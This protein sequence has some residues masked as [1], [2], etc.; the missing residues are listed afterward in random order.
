M[1]AIFRDIVYAITNLF[2]SWKHRDFAKQCN[3]FNHILCWF[4]IMAAIFMHGFLC[5][6]K[7]FSN[8]EYIF[9]GNASNQVPGARVTFA[10]HFLLLLR[11]EKL[12]E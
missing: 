5:P 11:V 4:Y 8:F 7:F 10:R 1:F 12:T 2:D 3:K 6:G 9:S